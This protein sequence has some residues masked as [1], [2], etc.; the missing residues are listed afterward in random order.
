MTIV[1]AGVAGGITSPVTGWI[2]ISSDI[3][4]FA[5]RKTR[6]AKR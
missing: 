4:R 3:E 1:A 5:A 6:A 2:N